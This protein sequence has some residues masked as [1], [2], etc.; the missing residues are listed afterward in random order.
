MPYW[1]LKYL[2]MKVIRV[3]SLAINTTIKTLR[4]KPIWKKPTIIASSPS[5]G[6]A[7]QRVYTDDR[8][9]DECM[10]VYDGMLF[11]Y[12]KDTI[13]SQLLQVMTIII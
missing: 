4:L 6:F 1:L 8:S 3:L 7:L 9:L 11:K 12:Q 13:R 2:Q 10:A 5:Q